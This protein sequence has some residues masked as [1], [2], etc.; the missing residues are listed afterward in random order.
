MLFP[1]CFILVQFIQMIT[2]ATENQ[3][4]VT[5]QHKIA[6]TL[7]P[8]SGSPKPKTIAYLSAESSGWNPEFD[9]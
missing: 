2:A 7:K 4:P 8:E 1:I 3:A 9:S 5:S 6:V